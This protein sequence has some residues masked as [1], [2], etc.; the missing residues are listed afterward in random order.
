MFL[1]SYIIDGI[2]QATNLLL[3]KAKLYTPEDTMLLQNSTK[4]LPVTNIFWMIS[5]WLINETPYAAYVEYWVM[6]KSYNYYKAGGRRAGW[7]P[8]Y[9]WVGARMFTRAQFENENQVRLIV[10]NKINEWIRAFNS[11]NKK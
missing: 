7:H 5:W 6:S 4:E 2:E 9:T 8:F 1:D 11:Q 3:N 10:M